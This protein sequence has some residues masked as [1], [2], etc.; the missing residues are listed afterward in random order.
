VI[1]NP[2]MDYIHQ[3]KIKKLLSESR[4]SDCL[5]Q[6]KISLETDDS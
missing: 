4:L 1:T 6:S 5:L 2:Q 3:N